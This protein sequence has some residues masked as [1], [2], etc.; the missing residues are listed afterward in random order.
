MPGQ[1]AVKQKKPKPV[2]LVTVKAAEGAVQAQAEAGQLGAPDPKATQFRLV[3]AVAL[4]PQIWKETEPV[5]AGAV[6]R[7]SG[8]MLRVAVSV[9]DAPAV[10]VPVLLACVVRVLGCRTKKHSLVVVVLAELV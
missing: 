1:L 7:F 9:M 4:G 5:G 6:A 3:L 10:T 8:A 2:V